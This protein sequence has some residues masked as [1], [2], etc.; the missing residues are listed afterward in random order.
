MAENFSTDMLPPKARKGRRQLIPKRRPNCLERYFV[1]EIVPAGVF[2]LMLH[3]NIAFSNALRKILCAVVDAEVLYRT[4]P[5]HFPT[6]PATFTVLL[7]VCLE[8]VN[9]TVTWRGERTVLTLHSQRR[10]H[11]VPF[12]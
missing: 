9:V 12:P 6:V 10:D 7:T 8:V 1:G 11:A 3:D 2:V 5:A 4:Y